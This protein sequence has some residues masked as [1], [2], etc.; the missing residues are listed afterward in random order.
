MAE[1][2]QEAAEQFVCSLYLPNTKMSEVGELRWLFFKQKQAL[3]EKLPPTK[4]ALQQA[5]LRAHYQAMIWE[6]DKT[7]SPQ[8]LP[9]KGMDG[10]K[11][12]SQ[13]GSQ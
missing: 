13:N 11:M 7:A 3:S 12:M 4:A 8:S 2:A 10:R 9:Q 5:V 6:N 1:L